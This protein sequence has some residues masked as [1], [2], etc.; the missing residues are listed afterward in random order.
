MN[1]TGYGLADADKLNELVTVDIM[2][3]QVLTSLGKHSARNVAEEAGAVI[4]IGKRTVF[5]VDK[6]RN[7]L[8]KLAE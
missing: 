3:L 2:G 4:K 8:N 1:K 5:S 6:I 7:Y